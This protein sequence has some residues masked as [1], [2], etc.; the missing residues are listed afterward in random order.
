V[1]VLVLF[2][3][4]ALERSRVNRA[5]LRAVQG[6]PAVTLHDLYETYPDL[7]IDV[8]REQALLLA[9]DVFVFQHPFYWYS[10]P[11]IL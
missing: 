4:P 3:H 2:A 11:S 9:H 6:T 10:V 1:K 5:L 7:Q 8:G